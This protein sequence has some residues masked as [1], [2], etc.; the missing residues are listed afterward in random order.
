MGGLAKPSIL[1]WPSSPPFFRR[2]ISS[3]Y[4]SKVRPLVFC[5]LY[6]IGEAGRKP[7]SLS[8][9]DCERFAI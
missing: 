4:L 6:L 2:S 3:F 8:M 5:P 7:G 1:S 9:T